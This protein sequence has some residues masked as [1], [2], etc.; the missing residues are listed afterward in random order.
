MTEE[1]GFKRIGPPKVT[2][3]IG[4]LFT[5]EIMINGNPDNIWLECFRN[6]SRFKYNEAHPSNA[7]I[8]GSKITFSWAESKIRESVIDLDSYIQQAN[9]CYNKKMSEKL[10]AEKRVQDE[11]MARQADIYRVN[12]SLKDL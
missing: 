7:I 1:T 9:E 11:A 4:D 3:K 12:E 5:V 10:S 2:E 8:V 6:P